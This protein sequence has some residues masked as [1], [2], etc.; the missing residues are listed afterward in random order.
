MPLAA[1]AQETR[2]L[3]AEIRLG[4]VGPLWPKRDQPQIEKGPTRCGD[5]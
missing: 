4:E 3:K 1:S 5:S 2:R